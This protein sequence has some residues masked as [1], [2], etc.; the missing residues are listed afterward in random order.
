[1]ESSRVCHKACQLR[2]CYLYGVG[3]KRKTIMQ[4][5]HHKTIGNFKIEACTND[6]KLHS[7]DNFKIKRICVSH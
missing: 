5:I 7:K 6:K 4:K 2:I 3:H 1:M